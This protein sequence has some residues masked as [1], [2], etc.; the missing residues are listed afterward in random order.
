[1]GE[2]GIGTDAAAQ[3]IRSR[4][5]LLNLLNTFIVLVLF[6]IILGFLFEPL[7]F[8]RDYLPKISLNIIVVMALLL[9]LA[10]SVMS[11]MLTRTVYRMIIDFGAKLETVLHAS[12]EIAEEP[13]GD[14]LFQK[15]MDYALLLTD[16]EAG[17]ILT[18]DGEKLVFSIA[19]GVDIDNIQEWSIPRDDGLPGWVA[20]QGVPLYIEDVSASPE[21]QSSLDLISSCKVRNALCVPLMTKG[22]AVGVIE[23]VNKRHETYN[24]KDLNAAVYLAEQAASNIERARKAEDDLNFQVHMTGVLVEAIDYMVPSSQNHSREVARYTNVLTR[25]LNLT[26]VEQRQFHFA[27]LLHDIGYVRM[28]SVLGT[29]NADLTKHAE[30]GYDILK[31]INLYRDLAP[32]VLHHHEHFDGSGY[33]RGLSGADIPLGSRI[34]AVAQEFYRLNTSGGSKED[35][36]EALRQKGDTELDPHLVEIFIKSAS[37]M[38]E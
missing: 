2:E 21:F 10:G 15:I 32:M 9:T 23:L 35:I 28:T 30:L 20:S 33:P 12:K 6:G 18:P 17:A 37:E 4:L 24:E 19:K 13:H 38:M 22:E 34:I 5:K 7:G 26:G 14:I 25:G 29:Q 8:I 31:E 1:M 16:S 3:E 11:R 27:A 36:F